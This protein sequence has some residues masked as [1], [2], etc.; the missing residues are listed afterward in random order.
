MAQRAATILARC[1]A[2]SSSYHSR[3]KL[4]TR[5]LLPSAAPGAVGRRL[6]SRGG[7]PGGID[8][9]SSRRGVVGG[10]ARQP[11]DGLAYAAGAVA[12]DVVVVVGRSQIELVGGVEGILLS[13]HLPVGAGQL[14]RYP[15][16]AVR[17]GDAAT[18]EGRIV[19]RQCQ[20][21]GDGDFLAVKAVVP[22]VVREDDFLLRPQH[23]QC[24]Q[25]QGEAGE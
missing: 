17:E 1:A 9:V 18:P 4:A 23:G 3:L 5:R 11:G 20:C 19:V 22:E 8:G 12:V 10:R 21:V 6:P 16:Q 14:G 13:E 15:Q 7:L 25:L 24:G 2:S